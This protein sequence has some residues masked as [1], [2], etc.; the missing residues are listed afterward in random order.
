MSRYAIPLGW[1]ACSKCGATAAL[2]RH[3]VVPLCDYGRDDHTNV[4]W[5]CGTCHKRWHRIAQAIRPG[6]ELKRF[7]RWVYDRPRPLPLETALK[8]SQ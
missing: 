8:E 2:H 7:L 3:H 5:L 4:V 1:P 6:Q